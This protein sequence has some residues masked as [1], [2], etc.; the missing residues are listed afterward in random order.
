M[1]D[2]SPEDVI[3]SSWFHEYEKQRT[4][5]WNQL[6]NLNSSLFLLEKIESL[7][8]SL[9]LTAYDD[10]IFWQMTKIALWERCI[11]I[12]WRVAVD[13]D[14]RTLTLKNFKDNINANLI[15]K[16]AN[17]KWYKVDF[18]IKELQNKVRQVRHNFLAHLNL[19][20]QTNPNPQK[21]VEISISSVD[22]RKAVD[23]LEVLFQ[24]LCFNQ[25][26]SLW[27]WAYDDNSR[28][29]GRTD[30]DKLFDALVKDSYL[31]NAPENDKNFFYENVINDYTDEQLEIVNSYRRR[32][33]KPEIR[34]PSSDS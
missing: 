12:I 4:Q 24:H 26:H 5:I 16:N 9:F 6:V 1:E 31:F 18:E 17:K 2:I 34:R 13:K 25:H 23:Q 14:S 30:I 32:F 7:P 28:E 11:M 19:K 27:L 10:R 8:L 3:E 22:L 21:I 29:K 15:E 33:Y 20:W